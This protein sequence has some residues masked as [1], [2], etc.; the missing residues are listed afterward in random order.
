MQLTVFQVSLCLFVITGLEPGQS[1]MFEPLES[2]D[3][4]TTYASDSSAMFQPYIVNPASTAD[5]VDRLL[6][7]RLFLDNIK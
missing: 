2:K 5:M 3:L 7:K 1:I 4:T 6:Y